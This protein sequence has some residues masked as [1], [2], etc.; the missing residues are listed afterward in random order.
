MLARARAT[1]ENTRYTNKTDTP[2]RKFGDPRNETLGN[3][4]WHGAF[5][6]EF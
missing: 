6:N 2:R 4:L 5:R 3:H 1:E